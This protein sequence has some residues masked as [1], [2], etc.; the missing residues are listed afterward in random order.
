[1]SACTWQ[2]AQHQQSI[3]MLLNMAETWQA[4][5]DERRRRQAKDDSAQNNDS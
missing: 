4:L 3:R 1:M 2:E 5:A